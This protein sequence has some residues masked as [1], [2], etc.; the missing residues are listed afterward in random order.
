MPTVFISYS[1]DS[2]EHTD[3]VRKLADRL[4]HDGI[5]CLF[6]QYVSAFPPEDWTKWMEDG[7]EKADF[8]LLV[9]TETYLRRVKGTEKKGMGLG[10][11]W[12][13]K[14][15]YNHI[16]KTGGKNHCFIPVIFSPEDSE[17]IP[18]PL[19]GGPRFLLNSEKNYETLYR[20]L[21][22][23]PKI[24]K[25]PIGK[26]K[27]LPQ[28]EP[29]PLCFDSSESS[30]SVPG[31]PNPF[32]FGGPV[33]PEMFYGRED[34]LQTLTTRIGGPSL[35]STSV[36]GERRM[37]KSSLLMYVRERLETRLPKHHAY[38]FIY[39]DLMQGIFYTRK[40]MMRYLRR[41]LSK[42]WQE[43]WP[44]DED[45]DLEAFD[46]ALDDLKDDNIRL[47]LCLDEMENLTR[48][49]DEFN[50][51]LEDWRACGSRGKMGMITASRI[52]LADLRQQ[53]GVAS[54]FDNIFITENL[55]LL[56][57]DEWQ[58]LIR[59]HMRV[60]DTELQWIEDMAG[61]H[62]AFTQLA[63]F[64]LWE[65]KVRGIVNAD[66]FREVLRA[67]IR[68]HLEYLWQKLSPTEQMALR[69]ATGKS[70]AKPSKP[71]LRHLT[72]RGVLRNRRPFCTLF[73]EFIQEKTA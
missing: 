9:C 43:P 19:I 52:S 28:N 27:K 63:G 12:E 62:P 49:P 44:K 23:Q 64:R 26:I 32:C 48:R 18:I 17:H 51:L 31:G 57:T 68:P 60:S 37:G 42:A 29:A 41:K 56:K 20:V 58:A 55:G 72:T 14:L 21:T 33:R 46:F 13:G 69:H 1:H 61:G 50:D 53:G 38:V 16:Y 65:M 5:D 47:I 2:E 10:V 4:S 25:P 15:I 40:G 45:G 36:V 34:I 39:L 24:M 73:D 30:P 7:L 54:P 59:D 8:V 22:D 3:R 66:Q 6:D 35:Q 71:V 70:L 11:R 67:D